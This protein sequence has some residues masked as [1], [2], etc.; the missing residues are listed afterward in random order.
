MLA[1]YLHDTTS[2]NPS[3]CSA[4]SHGITETRVI[5]ATHHFENVHRENEE[6]KD[7]FSLQTP[8]MVE[9]EAE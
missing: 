5:V 8:S 7:W 1:F 9:H 3:S 6:D 4:I 2:T